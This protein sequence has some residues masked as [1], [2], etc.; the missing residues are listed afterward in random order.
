M[1]RLTLALTLML[2]A[3]T[4]RQATPTNADVGPARAW[5]PLGWTK[6]GARPDLYDVG[7]DSLVRRTGKRSA[8]IAAR[9]G[10]THG[11]WATLSQGINASSYIGRRM[12]VAAWIRRDSPGACQGFVA[13]DGEYQ[14]KRAALAFASEVENPQPCGTEWRRF[15]IVLD[16]PQQARRMVY[17]YRLS[18]AGRVWI[19]DVTVGPVDSTVAVSPQL[20]GLPAVHRETELRALD[21]IVVELKAR[22]EWTEQPTNLGF[23][24]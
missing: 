9:A 10:V 3:C 2:S 23:D 11:T 14:G 4:S 8:Y 13:I 20:D 19:D 5:I 22:G 6:A 1:R 24:E 7:I 12:S 16:V 15:S 21:S 17:G 18:G